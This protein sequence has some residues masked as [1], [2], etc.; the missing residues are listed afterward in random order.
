MM[1]GPYLVPDHAVPFT[2]EGTFIVDG[3]VFRYWQLQ[4]RQYASI[5][6]DYRGMVRRD[7]EGGLPPYIALL[8][9]ERLPGRYEKLHDGRIAVV[10]A[11]RVIEEGLV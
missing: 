3:V 8:D 10:A 1:L 4:K 2:H 7:P 11:M 6:E 9:G 5:T